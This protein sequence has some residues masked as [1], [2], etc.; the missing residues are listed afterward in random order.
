MRFGF[1]KLLINQRHKFCVTAAY[2]FLSDGS[3][4]WIVSTCAILDPPCCIAIIAIIIKD[5]PN[6][7]L[8]DFIFL[9]CI[10]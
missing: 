4:V 5:I 2:S 7:S 8:E 6:N 1:R 10:F 3:E 9:L